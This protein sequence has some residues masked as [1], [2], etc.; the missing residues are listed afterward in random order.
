M[1]NNM[2]GHS[3]SVGKRKA[4]RLTLSLCL[5]IALIAN[6]GDRA[7]S[8]SAAN[9]GIDPLE[10]L[11]LQIRNN[12]IILLD[13]S[14]SM[15]DAT[16]Y[17]GFSASGFA[18]G[19]SAGDSPRSKMYN[20]KQ[21]ITKIIKDNETKVSFQFGR[22][23][24]SATGFGAP[25]YI[26]S[27]LTNAPAP[28]ASC[29][30]TSTTGDA[31]A[32][33]GGFARSASDER[34]PAGIGGTEYYLDNATYR[35][36][37]QYRIGSGGA[38]C[39]S[40]SDT[41]I[42][43]GA[44]TPPLTPSNWNLPNVP[45][46]A[47]PSGPPFVEF[48]RYTN[49]GCTGTP[50]TTRFYFRGVQ[51]AN[52]A[53]DTSQSCGGFRSLVGLADCDDNDQLSLIGPYVGP[54]IV[55]TAVSGDTLANLT[56]GATATA[57]RASGATPL[58]ESLIDIRTIFQTDGDLQVAGTQASL[59]ST[60][61]AQSPKQRTFVIVLTDGDDS[62]STSTT[63]DASG[64]SNNTLRAAHKAQQLYAGVGGTPDPASRVPTFVVA[65]GGAVTGDIINTIAWG[66]SGMVRSGTQLTGSGNAQRWA[67]VPSAADRAACTTCIDAFPASDLD[68]LT[69]ALQA[70]IDQGSASGEFSDQ[71]SVTE[72]VYEFANVAG[73][74]PFLPDERYSVSVPVLLQ[75]T[76][77]LPDYKGHLNAF[78]RG[79]NG[80]PTNPDDDV[81]VPLWDAG[82]ELFDRVADS[83]HGMTV[84]T[85]YRFSALHG[86]ATPADIRDS[87]AKIK[88]RIFTT[89]QNGINANYTASN[90][91]NAAFGVTGRNAP[92]GLAGSSSGMWR[93]A[94]WPPTVANSTGQVAP[95]S[96]TIPGA[97]DGAMGFDSLTTLAQVQAA[98]PGAC[99]GTVV[100][101]I[102]DACK[103][104]T[105]TANILLRAK[106]EAREIVLAFIAGARV[107]A[108]G[109]IPI[110]SNTGATAERKQ[111]QYVVRPWILAEST[112]AAPGVVTP[113]LLAGPVAAAGAVG[114]EEYKRYRDGLNP[115]GVPVNHVPNGLGLRNPDRS[116]NL[117]AQTAA[118][119]N[120]DI[121]PV[122]SVIYHA[123]NMGLHA[124]RAGP[125]PTAS[126]SAGLGSTAVDC[127]DGVG[128][129][130]VGGEE[131]WAFIP[132]DL[133]NKLPALVR[134]QS[135]ATKQY[136][137]AAPVRFSDVF[138]P[139]PGG[140]SFNGVSFTG[141]WRTL[142]Y[143]GRGQGGKYYT[144]LDVT[145]PGPF[146]KHSLNTEPPIVVWSRG[147]PDTT[148]GLAGGPAVNAADTLKY[149]KMGETWS[150]PAI[151]FVTA[152][153]YGG[154]DFVLFTGSG[155]SDVVGEG[156]TFYVLNALNG[157][158][159]KHLNVADGAPAAPPVLVPPLPPLTNFLVASPVYYAEDAEG[160]SPSG[161]RF[162]GNPISAKVKTVY[163]PDLHGRIFRFDASNPGAYADGSTPFTSA[164]AFFAVNAGADGNQ[165]FA[166]PVSILQD[167]PDP[168]V[169]ATVLVY[170]ESGHDRR[171][172]VQ[173]AKPFKAYAFRDT[174][175]VRSNIFTRNF[176]EGYR[177]T[178][179]P[180][181]AFAGTALPP[182]PVVFYAGV[183]FNPPLPPPPCASRFDS[184][185]VALRGI[186][187]VAGVP[188]EAFD[189]KATG[190]DSFIEML[191]TKINA[192]RVSGEGNLVIDQGLNA[193]NAP[194]PPGV[195]PP[196]ETTS[197][198]SSLVTVG[199]APG[200]DAFKALSA[201][202]VPYRVGSSVC[203]T[204]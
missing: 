89:S 27:C 140:V 131:L 75:S 161:Y 76:F 19:E 122:M 10:V 18:D 14:G 145:T 65:F 146:T 116:S 6:L 101:D 170:A 123:T 141:V 80:T 104:P 45:A 184:I 118:T 67:S 88:R 202:T 96:D 156:K 50:T 36:N 49:T 51:W 196:S 100:A 94:L 91:L 15:R 44:W 12:A 120:P 9:G 115:T 111:L 54:E 74:D 7:L 47:N 150:V 136:L 158:V 21:A 114:V 195:A 82:Q 40:N 165:P 57:V 56:S 124:F 155:Y 13:S 110:R 199:L 61:S 55:P 154:A 86:S 35:V 192:I 107:L 34:V 157:N 62:C 144:A 126:S 183:K 52:K 187:T 197:T 4:S 109:T 134:P 103:S 37:R 70:A 95:D 59:W 203:R 201:T 16:D 20:A 179:Q 178:V 38:A 63:F 149:A 71:Q 117:A 172:A 112:L 98:V 30:N 58:A 128:A 142:L 68:S 99:Q 160:K 29:G 92:G 119:A 168:A 1:E 152:A 129:P 33:L 85:A 132:H 137:L 167:Q 190:D 53:N 105:S 181:T 106:R 174:D 135:R 204:P 2:N 162:I 191:G 32:F 173:A 42:A 24:Q 17:S 66:G 11:N 8:A 175:G 73:A 26:Y 5:G 87:S 25:N 151:G 169:P 81:T 171:V 188:E 194:P 79:D 3:T 139:A 93:A 163:F 83:T 127:Q 130:E 125:C 147:N 121:K 166:T 60:I 69:V 41:A 164:S 48:L 189:L 193:Q 102:P 108:N 28:E 186:S 133:L 22:Y 64:S 77:E 200:S 180:A 138:V 153:N 198:S 23:E 72:T 176:E 182:T 185:I 43:T 78:R 177:G 39:A 46:G 97:F 31:T 90:L 159:I 143:F 148:D 84:G 113:P